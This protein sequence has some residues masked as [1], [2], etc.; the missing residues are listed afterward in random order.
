MN[1]RCLITHQLSVFR[2]LSLLCLAALSNPAYAAES[3]NTFDLILPYTD[4]TVGQGQDV[5]MD[6]EVVNRGKN[7]VKVGIEIESVPEKWEVGFYSR[8]PSYPVRSVM[9]Q[10]E[11]STTVEFK[12]EIPKNANPGEYKIKVTAKDEKGTTKQIETITLRV[13]SEKIKVGGLEL[14]S[15]YPDLSGPT[16]QT[17]KFTVDLK[18]ET[19][20]PLTAALA[21]RPPAGWLVRF[22][23]QFGDTQISSIALK[24]DTTETLSI[25]IDS[26]LRAEPGD[27]SLSVHARSGAVEAST[28][29]KVTLT[30]TYDLKMGFST[31]TLSTSITAGE[32]TP[33]DFLVANAGTAPI[34]SLSFITQKPEKWTVEFKPDKIDTLKPE[35]VREVKMEISAPPRTVA[36]DYIL[37]LTSTN[38]DTSKSV[39]LRV[40]VSTPTLW[41][42]IGALIVLAVVIGLGFVFVRL[43]RR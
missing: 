31:G 25:D 7:P 3:K 18:N 1:I 38:P 36:G 8:Y 9:V 30:G 41:G 20:K 29:L 19:Q 40:T 27:Y 15:Q 39:D 10:G 11:K 6:A 42:W 24:E 2:I 28:D 32:K 16:G 22:K 12:A 5:T 33:V 13:T 21:A 23:P 43:G 14:T 37:T 26:P 35:E 17:F 4:I 34:R